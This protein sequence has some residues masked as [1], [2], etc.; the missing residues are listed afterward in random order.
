MALMRQSENARRGRA[1]DN[2]DLVKRI[3]TVEV[4]EGRALQNLGRHTVQNFLPIGAIHKQLN[5][6]WI[7]EE[8]AAVGVICTHGD[9]PR[10]LHEQIPFQSDGP[11]PSVD[12]ALL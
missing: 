10:V 3:F 11:L 9:A 12:K 5:D 4:F 8:G 1:G 7:S 6:L 2:G